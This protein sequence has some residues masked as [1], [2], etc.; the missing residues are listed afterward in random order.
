MKILYLKTLYL[1]Y[2]TMIIHMN[3]IKYILQYHYR[4][5][6]IVKFHQTRKNMSGQ[7]SI[8]SLRGIAS[9]TYRA[10]VFTVNWRTE[11]LSRKTNPA[12]RREGGRETRSRST[13]VLALTLQWTEHWTATHII[14][15]ET[16]NM[17]YL[18]GPVHSARAILTF[19]IIKDYES[20]N[21]LLLE[22]M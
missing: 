5:Q 3:I 15:T 6:F 12:R 20:L 1:I 4:L 13:T 9:S 17:N 8:S 16:W 21:R 22:Y 14:K 18:A 10:P 2:C 11:L 7:N 19:I